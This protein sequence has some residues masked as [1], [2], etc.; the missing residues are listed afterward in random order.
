[1]KRF[2]VIGLG[3]FGAS[4]AE[5]LYNQ[6]HEVVAVDPVE[7]AVDRVAPHV[8]RAALGDGKSLPVLER[9]GARNADA[10]IVSTGDDIT[11][12]ILSVMALRDL[13]VKDIYVKVISRDHA[14][15]MSRIGVT[16]TIFPE[17]ESAMGLGARLSG[18]ALLNYVRLSTGFSLQE[19]AVRDDWI[20]RTLRQLELRQR[21]GISV[22]AVHDILSD[23]IIS[24][25]DPDMVLK[26]SV[27]LLVAG[28]DEDLSK[29]AT[30]G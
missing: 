27:T 13:G 5:A 17:R 11:A 23:E 1:M 15:V 12:S 26:E 8:T 30:D 7:D 10:G 2:V 28:R 6:G 21:H 18:T 16:E 14:R 25:P 3:N 19:M 9:I 24:P 29:A 20:G 22:I 4:V